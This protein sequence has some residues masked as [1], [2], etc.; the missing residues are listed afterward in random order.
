MTTKRYYIETQIRTAVKP[1]QHYGRFKAERRLWFWQAL[2]V[3]GTVSA[4]LFLLLGAGLLD[5]VA[6][7]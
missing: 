7:I 6:G 4:F 2:A 3:I 1:A 5:W